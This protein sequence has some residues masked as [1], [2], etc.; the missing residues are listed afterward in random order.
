MPLPFD[1]ESESYGSI[2]L[3]E[4]WDRWR[5]GHRRSIKWSILKGVAVGNG[6]VSPNSGRDTAASFTNSGVASGT[7]LARIPAAKIGPKDVNIPI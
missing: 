1:L 6:R 2:S 5:N 3:V 7:P 4:W